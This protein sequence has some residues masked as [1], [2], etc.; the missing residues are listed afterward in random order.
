MRRGPQFVGVAVWWGGGAVVEAVEQAGQVRQGF[1]CVVLGPFSLIC[2]CLAAATGVH[3]ALLRLQSS[4]WL[5]VGVKYQDEGAL[6]AAAGV[7]MLS[8][9]FTGRHHQP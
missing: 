8:V 9:L 1:L 5:A 3:I 6:A 2:C 7:E 4:H